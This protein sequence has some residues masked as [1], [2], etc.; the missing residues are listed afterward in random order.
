M[1]GYDSEP[2]ILSLI[3]VRSTD[4]GKPE[5]SFGLPR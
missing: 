5:L 1:N 4:D 2:P 3:T